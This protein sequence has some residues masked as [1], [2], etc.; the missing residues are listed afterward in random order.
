MSHKHD[1]TGWQGHYAGPNQGQQYRCI[2]CGVGG[3]SSSHGEKPLTYNC[4][5][6]TGCGGKA[7]MWPTPQYAIYRALF[8]KAERM[9]KA[10]QEIAFSVTNEPD[11][12]A[13]LTLKVA[14][15]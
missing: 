9:Q 3:G 11:N 5:D 8:I 13:A 7:T 1:E 12:Y 6:S 15:T 4:V 10:L 2:V 14:A